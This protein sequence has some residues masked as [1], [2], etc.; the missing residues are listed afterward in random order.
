MEACVRKLCMA[1]V[2]N[3]GFGFEFEF[4]FEGGGFV[5]LFGTKTSRLSQ[6]C[7][8]IHAKIVGHLPIQWSY[9]VLAAQVS[10]LYVCVRTQASTSHGQHGNGRDNAMKWKKAVQTARVSATHGLCHP[11]EHRLGFAVQGH[12]A[13]HFV[14][15]HGINLLDEVGRCCKQRRALYCMTSKSQHMACQPSGGR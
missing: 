13:H 1:D 3:F 2:V 9:G 11:L 7:K 14:T 12:W 6:G 10:T 5:R 15:K 8:T 4:E